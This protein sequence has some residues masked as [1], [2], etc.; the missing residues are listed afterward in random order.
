MVWVH[1]EK[2]N[3]ILSRLGWD[4]FGIWDKKSVF[5]DTWHLMNHSLQSFHH[6]VD[7]VLNICVLL[8]AQ[9][10]KKVTF[11]S[12]FHFSLNAFVSVN[13]RGPLNTQTLHWF[14]SKKRHCK[15]TD[16]ITPSLSCRSQSVGVLA[17]VQTI[18]VIDVLKENTGMKR[19]HLCYRVVPVTL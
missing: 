18:P 8:W 13:H 11:L 19:W 12:T 10:S 3:V 15:L 9:M 6:M 4:Y 7:L 1:M 16:V 5:S 2:Y 17:G 14:I